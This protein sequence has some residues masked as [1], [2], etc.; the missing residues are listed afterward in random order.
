MSNQQSRTL[1]IIRHAKSSW[2]DPS[3]TDFDRP[4]NRR[5]NADGPHMA[6]W[7]ARQSPAASW[8]WTSDAARALATTEFVRSGFAAAD[9]HAV[10]DHR[11]YHATPEIIFQ[12]LG[13]T[14]SDVSCAAVVAHNPGLTYVVNLLA[15]RTAIDNLPTFGIARFDF[16]GTWAG[17]GPGE[18]ILGQL[19]A[20]KLLS[21]TRPFPDGA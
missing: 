20:P 11:L 9:P 13:E 5:G 3:Q 18:G 4:L 8:I 21:R 6:Q 10:H 16:R 12:V 1:W 7:L 17:L 19:M 2:G 15:R 14:P